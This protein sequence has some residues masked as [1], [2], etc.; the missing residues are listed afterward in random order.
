MCTNITWS[1]F[2]FE[3][4]FANIDI[5]S[6][7]TIPVVLKFLLPSSI[8]VKSFRKTA[9]QIFVN[10]N[11]KIKLFYQCK[12]QREYQVQHF[13]ELFG[14]YVGFQM[15]WVVQLE[16]KIELRTVLVKPKDHHICR[17][18]I[19]F[20]TSQVLLSLCTQP[21]LRPDKRAINVLKL[22]NLWQSYTFSNWC[23]IFIPQQYV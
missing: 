17:I 10:S 19:E 8:K 20:Y 16:M 12:V 1:F 7:L 2:T 14:N 13:W 5:F 22:L 15:N 9:T 11:N 18:D 6:K 21:K 4:T 3:N 23:I